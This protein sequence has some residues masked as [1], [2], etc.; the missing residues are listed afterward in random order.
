MTTTS[1]PTCIVD[2]P[3][4]TVWALLMRPERWG[5][6]YDLRIVSVKPSG[7]ATIGQTVFAESGPRL[8]HLKVEFRFTKIDSASHGLAV[9]ARLPFGITVREDMSCHPL[10]P[11]Q[12]RVTYNCDFG[13]PAGWRG[14]V[15]KF[16]LR[17]ELDSGPANSLSR[18]R[19]AA[20]RCHAD[21]TQARQNGSRNA[22]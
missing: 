14:A 4:E 7:L 12:C 20:E 11:D 19:R 15:L 18:L 9:E 5:D 6:F 13:F 2:A 21:D 8:L 16:L 22:P 10:G 3:V 1:C 17:R